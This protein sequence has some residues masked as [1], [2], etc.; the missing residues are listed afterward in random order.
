MQETFNNQTN[1]LLELFLDNILIEKNLSN[2]T[3]RAYKTDLKSF[4]NYLYNK[5]L[6]LHKCKEVDITN[7]LNSLAKNDIKISTKIRKISVVCQFMK[8]LF[9]EKII[10]I[11]P[12]L[13]INLPK[14]NQSLPN[15][16]EEK[17]LNKIFSYLYDNN[18]NFK[19]FQLLVLTELLYATGLRVSELVTLKISDITDDYKQIYVKGKGNKERLLPMG[20]VVIKLLKKYVNELHK[21]NFFLNEKME[22]KV[23]WL[24]PSAKKHITR[25]SYY[26]NLKKIGS[27]VG[28]DNSKISPHSL[29]H[30]FASHMLKNGADLKV[31]QHLLGHED[32][33]TVQI[34]IHIN[35]RETKK[36]IEKHPIANYLSDSIDKQK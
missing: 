28:L 31:I 17:E 9:N 8:F 2:A 34:Y 20:E 36:A 30:A 13:K 33:S 29:R 12:T 35:M 6:N 22:E 27:A 25:Q 26:L 15:F 32:I 18:K 4:S 19:N 21:S 5:G 16:L 23:F 14:K 24:F 3:L 7:W 10:A 11:N 1:N